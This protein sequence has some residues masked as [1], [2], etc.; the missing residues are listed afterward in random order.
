LQSTTIWFRWICSIVGIGLV[1]CT[2]SFSQ[3]APN[4]GQQPVQGQAAPG[5]PATQSPR[6][7]PAAPT[8][9]NQGQAAGQTQAAPASVGGGAEAAL[10]Q[11]IEGPFEVSGIPLDQVVMLLQA[12]SGAQIVLGP[13]LNQTVTFSLQSPTVGEVLNTVLPA[14]GLDY[15]VQDTG[16]IYIDTAAKIAEMKA[17][18]LE[19][20]RRVFTPSFVD[21][22]TLQPAIESSLSPN[23]QV[24]IDPDSKRI[25]VQDVPAVIEAIEELIFSLDLR[26]ETRVFDIRYANAQEIADQLAGVINTVEGELFVDYR[27]N[28]III[29]DIPERLDEAAAIIEQLDIELEFVVVPLAFALPED[30]LV[31]VEGLLTENGYVDY[32]PR[33]SRLFIQDIPSVVE[34]ILR[35]IK[36]FDIPTQQVYIEADIVQVNND[37]SLTMGTSMG[38]GSDIGIGGNP[39]APNVGG[40]TEGAGNFFSFNPFLTTSGQGLTLLDVTRGKY[41]IQI[42]AMV[43]KEIAEVIA[44]PRLLVQD[45]GMGSFTLGSQEPFATRQQYG[46]YGGTGGDY[47]TQQFREVGTSLMLEV[48]ASEAGYVELYISVEDTRS[49]R[50]QLA[51]IGEGLAIDGSFIDTSVTVKSGRTVV[52]GGI[53]NRRNEDSRSGVPVLSSIPILG[54]LFRQK[55]SSST[56]QKLLVFITPTIV[57][58]DDPYEFAQVDNVQK[59][60]ELRK[61]GVTDFIETQV[62]PRFLDWENEEPFMEEAIE[63]GLKERGMLN[64]KGNLPPRA[65]VPEKAPPLREQMEDGIIRTYNSD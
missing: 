36:Q 49:R 9:M 65:T 59:I 22:A 37:K 62:D 42:D 44:S 63:E 38:L 51:N 57:S 2:I 17:P 60:E 15:I 50:V 28:R 34:Q 7:Q 21:V 56:K 14:N 30:I 39:S 41:R 3:Q 18:E 27:N 4:Q 20:I 12:Q 8:L 64:S 23:G 55:S 29:T 46:Y 26:T 61:T 35:L 48:Y 58:V 47:F 43:E 5:Q 24:F 53:I 31:L 33:T 6:P 10:S 11:R 52:L 16:V 40:A 54:A 19:V 25:I 13:N 1:F 32:D 45:G